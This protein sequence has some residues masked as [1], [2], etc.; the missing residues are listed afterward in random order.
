MSKKYSIP[1]RLKKNSGWGGPYELILNE[2]KVM[3]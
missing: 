2:S 3:F 1:D